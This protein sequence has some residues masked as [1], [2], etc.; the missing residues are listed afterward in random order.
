MSPE[1][2]NRGRDR[3]FSTFLLN[4]VLGVVF[5]MAL[6]IVV[7]YTVP[8]EHLIIPQHEV[9]ARVARVDD[10]ALSS[11][12]MET[13]GGQAVLV[14]RN[15]ESGYAAL[16]GTSP[17][18]GCL[19]EWD[20]DSRRVTSPCGH[21]LYDLRGQAVEGLTTAPLQRYDVFVRDGVVYVTRD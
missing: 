2:S 19:L 16:Q 13:L 15:S 11:S 7:I 14:V 1:H 17:V 12:R 8:P 18:D 9:A 20:S 4:S 10:F 5:L 6:A 21:Q 3:D